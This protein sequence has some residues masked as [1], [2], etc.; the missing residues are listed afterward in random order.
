MD[1]TRQI[2]AKNI[3][4]LR[5]SHGM[6]Q[7]DL[8][9][10]LRYSDKAVSKWERGESVP[11]IT[12]LVQ[13]AD[14][15]EVSLD[16]LVRGEKPDSTPVPAPQPERKK[17]RGLIIGMSVLLVWLIATLLF[18]VFVLTETGSSWRWLCFVYAV[19]ISLLVWLVLNSIWFNQR[20]NYL[21]ISFMMWSLLAALYLTL[22]PLGG[23]LWLIFLLGVPGQVILIFWSR[24][25]VRSSEKSQADTKKE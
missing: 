25:N 7:I 20:R 13:L 5:M 10:R 24:L 1:Q 4:T 23:H 15:F 19:P 8:A 17:R 16:K 3:N 2:L 12:V 18:I 14:L 9:E 11:D 22:F 21:I 6:T